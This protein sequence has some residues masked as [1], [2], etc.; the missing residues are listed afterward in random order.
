[1]T[2]STKYILAST[3][4]LGCLMQAAP[5]FSE[6]VVRETVT[7][8][9]GPTTTVKKTVTETAVQ[10]AAVRTETSVK[11][12]EHLVSGRGNHVNTYTYTDLDLNHDGILSMNEVGAILF[13]VY[14]VDGNGIID[15]NEYDRPMMVTINPVEKNTITSY[16]LDGD[17]TADE[18]H[19]TRETFLQDSRLARFGIVKTGLSAH[20]FIG[21]DYLDVDANRDHAIDLKE[22]Q[23]TY[24]A[25]IDRKNRFNAETNK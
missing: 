3:A 12:E 7:E 11:T 23:G 25:S 22:W 20:E 19:Y 2:H 13:K 14:D 18:T 15:N 1:M 17:G 9:P 16:D 10:P 8:M 5:S 24:I 4:L 21:R 6:T